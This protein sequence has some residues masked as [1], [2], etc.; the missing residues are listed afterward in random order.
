MIIQLFSC[1]SAIDPSGQKPS[2][3]TPSLSS[4]LIRGVSI[5]NFDPDVLEYD[6]EYDSVDGLP[7]ETDIGYTASHSDLTVQISVVKSTVKLIVTSPDGRS[8]V[9]YVVN[10]KEKTPIIKNTAAEI[11]NKNGAK[12]VL[13]LISDDGDQRTSDFFYTEIAPKYD[14]FKITIALP[15]KK[16]ASLMKTTDGS[17][18]KMD[19]NGNYVLTVL[20]N[21]YSSNI[22]G[23]VFA[24]S[25]YYP[26]TVDFW[27]KITSTGQIEI[28]SH[29]HTHA[30]WGLT[31]EQNGNYPAGN[32]IKEIRASAQI[33]R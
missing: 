4:I 15:T 29:S 17:A 21:D 22:A 24:K 13:T 16:V 31:D 33:I 14:S 8:N 25:S 7:R 23:S 2:T 6:F 11:V 9:I 12:G 32:V 10:M 3:I 1:I 27:N 30:A 26:T 5:A 19:E 20:K 28:A 18:W